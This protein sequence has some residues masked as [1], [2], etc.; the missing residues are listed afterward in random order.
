MTFIYTK[1]VLDDT[2]K[3]VKDCCITLLKKNLAILP[4]LLREVG[5]Y[6]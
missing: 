1:H 2:R 6:L 4:L 5:S 3:I